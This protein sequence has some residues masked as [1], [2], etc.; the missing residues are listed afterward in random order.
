[1]GGGE[2]ENVS[3]DEVDGNGEGEGEDLSDDEVKLSH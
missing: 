3:E 1:M 2:G